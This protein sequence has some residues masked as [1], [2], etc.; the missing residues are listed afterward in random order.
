MSI[1]DATPAEWD[2]SHKAMYKKLLPQQ[3]ELTFGEHSAARALDLQVG[4]THYK[5]MKIQPIEFIQANGCLL[6]TSPSPRDS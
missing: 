5:D 1:D 3:T 4:G 2:L 6:Y